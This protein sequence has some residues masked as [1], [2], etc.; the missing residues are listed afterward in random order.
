MCG[1]LLAYGDPVVDQKKFNVARDTLIHRG[2]DA[3]QSVFLEQGTLALGHTRLSIIDLS[4]RANQPMQSGSLWVTFNGE[5]YNHR[6]LRKDLEGAGAKFVTNSDTEVL[7]HGYRSWGQGLCEKLL[8]MFAFAIWD[9]ERKQVYLGRD[10]FGQKPLYY[11]EQGGTFFVASEIKAIKSFFEFNFPLRK[12]SLMDAM[13]Q[14]FVAEPNTWY[15]DI[16]TLPPGHSMTLQ[17]MPSGRLNRTISNFWG[18][19]PDPDP[20]PMSETNALANLEEQL[21]STIRSHLIADVEVGAFLSGGIDSNCITTLASQMQDA[22]IRTY[23]MGFGGNDELPLARETVARIGANHSEGMVAEEDYQG[24]VDRSLEIFD[25]PFGDTSIVPMERVSALAAQSVKV[26]LTGDGGDET[27]GGYDY[28]KFISPNLEFS[29]G[30]KQGISAWRS[31][32]RS[33]IDRC[34]WQVLGGEYY[35]RIARERIIDPRRISTRRRSILSP[36]LLSHLS[37]YDPSDAYSAFREEELCAFRNAQWIGIKVPLPS[38]MLEK[39]DRCS[40]LHS[41]ETRAPF[42]SPKLAEALLSLPIGVTNPS[43][44]WYKGLLRK[45]LEGKIPDNVL[46]AKKRGFDVPLEWASFDPGKLHSSKEI[47]P[48]CVSADLL[49]QGGWRKLRRAPRVL[50]YFNQIER[51]LAKGTL[52]C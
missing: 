7:L 40:M 37:G 19:K 45:W 36:S 34:A 10:H 3:Q 44:N 16:F 51:A 49:R 22:P 23:S 8:G 30:G 6:Q 1:I 26:V 5:I 4:N 9:D 24:F 12:E 17:K 13:V 32:F 43:N 21:D 42:L 52:K 25:Y 39:V 15:E 20:K 38:R 31:N 48:N 46:Y 41:L 11:T 14:D 47:F 18:F 50:W 2:P 27:F 33:F 29:D 28:G 35:A